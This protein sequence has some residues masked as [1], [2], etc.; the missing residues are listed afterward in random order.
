MNYQKVESDEHIET[1]VKLAE[2]IWNEHYPQIITQSQIEYMLQKYQSRAAVKRQLNQ[3][4]NYYLLNLA[5]SFIGYFSLIP[6]K[7][8]HQLQ[9]S[10]FYLLKNV[11]GKGHAKD[12]FRFILS[13]MRQ[14]KLNHI[15]LTVNKHNTTAIAAYE[16][17]G[18]VKT[19][20]L[21]ME[22]GNGYVMDDYK[23]DYFVNAK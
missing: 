2:E 13:I 23:M 4:E 12:M 17:S 3:G 11:R 9:L 15:W 19:D 21:V 18:F 6:D 20:S 8:N 1:V 5:N 22:I 7:D 10:K 14:Q 16:K